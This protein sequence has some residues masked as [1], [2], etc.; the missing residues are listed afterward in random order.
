MK[1]LNILLML[2]LIFIM[3]MA[4]AFAQVLPGDVG[5]EVNWVE[6]FGQLIA[7][8]KALSAAFIGALL[9]LIVVQTMKS[10]KLGSIYKFMD[11]KVQF[12]VVTV[13]GQAYGLMVH[14]LILKD[15]E[16]SMALVGFFSSG[17]AVAIFNAIKLL[18]EKKA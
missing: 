10:P 3:T 13:L 12:L 6:L 17:G 5:A 2:T 8:P 1:M 15:Q 16:I 11:P 18:S 7:N 4:S 9:I 14:T